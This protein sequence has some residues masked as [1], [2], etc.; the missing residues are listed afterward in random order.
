MNHEGEL[1]ATWAA[2]CEIAAAIGASGEGVRTVQALHS[3]A[4]QGRRDDE[5]WSERFPPPKT[6]ASR[7]APPS[8]ANDAYRTPEERARRARQAE[9]RRAAWDAITGGGGRR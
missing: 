3:A 9:E 7:P 8:D 5:F 4:V 6:I 1:R 2:I